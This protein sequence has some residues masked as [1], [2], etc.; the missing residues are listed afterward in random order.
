[1]PSEID[2]WSLPIARAVRQLF[3]AVDESRHRYPRQKMALADTLLSCAFDRQRGLY[4]PLA[5]D[6][7]APNKLTDDFSKVPSSLSA[8]EGT[9]FCYFSNPLLLPRRD[10]ALPKPLLRAT[11]AG[12]LVV[13]IEHDPQDREGLEEAVNWTTKGGE[14]YRIDVELSSYK[15]YAGF[16]A[17]YSGHK[18]VHLHFLFSTHHLQHAGSELAAGER[19]LAFHQHAGVIGAAHNAYYDR[20]DSL[21][22]SWLGSRMQ[23]DPSMRSYT[24]YRRTPWGIRVLERD[25]EILKL[26]AGTA[27]PQLVLAERIRTNRAAKGSSRF[28][29]PEDIWGDQVTNH[30]ASRT[31]GATLS[32]GAGVRLL[33]E[34]QL[35][36]MAA[37][38][39]E[40][41]K[42]VRMHRD[43]GEWVINFQNHPADRNPS[44]VCRGSH[45]SLLIQG[46]RASQ[47]R[48]V[49]PG[50]LTANETGNYLALRFGLMSPTPIDVHADNPATDSRFESLKRQSGRSFKQ[51][52]EAAARQSFAV[53]S[54][55]DVEQLQARYRQKLG[56]ITADCRS[57]NCH[58]I[59]ESA[60]GVGKTQALFGFM[61]E[62][63]LDT[64]LTDTDDT[65]RFNAFAFR[66]EAQAIAKAHEYRQGTG[67]GAFIWRSFWS[68]YAQVSWSLQQKPIPKAEFDEETNIASV[69]DRI[70]SEQPAVFD[71]LE[72]V[73]RTLWT[74]GDGRRLFNPNTVLFTTHATVMT[75]WV[76]RLTRTW[77]HPDF[78][79][80]MTDID[81][82]NL[83]RSVILQDVA[84][85]EPEYDELI[86]L[87][88]ARLYAHLASVKEWDWKRRPAN[89]R[90]DLFELIRRSG[91]IPA[92]MTFE[93]YSE[94]RYLDLNTLQEVEVDYWSQPFGRESTAKS[95]Y[96]ACH[97]RPFYLGA[98]E[99][100]FAGSARITFL[101]TEAFTTEAISAVYDKARQPLLRMQLDQL[102][103]LYPI[104]VPVVKE[105]RARAQDIQGLAREILNSNDNAVVIADGLGEL[106]GDRA[107]TFQ[108][109]KGHNGLSEND[110]YIIT[111]F[112]APE[113]YAR[114]NVLGQWTE[115]QD[116]VAKYYAAQISQAV[117]RN[118][119]FRQKAGTKTVVAISD[120]L[121]RLTGPALKKLDS[122]F[123]LL[124]TP[125]R[126]W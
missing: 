92:E 8:S 55:E 122:R 63:A 117:G 113:V 71:R 81:M 65:T 41:P 26:K 73:R 124:P 118:T 103:G 96:R 126:M 46:T 106:K 78:D 111:T 47:E 32:T 112:L 59:I 6:V 105:R 15:E 74:N 109:M 28:L 31:H 54:S 123:S 57:F 69:I 39:L 16:A 17:V 23:A 50:E 34:L 44:T 93:E 43:R 108:G 82:A 24:Q 35:M 9:S 76:G 70:R 67:R 115:Q 116:I 100:P 83:R 48:L 25:S 125:D 14:L 20:V 40:Y 94:L 97:Q 12:F 110:V 42:P 29:V 2:W 85:D 33:S 119:G 75:W 4:V 21:C 79:P 18:S 89:E 5:S 13:T 72:E 52:F 95:I 27:V 10:E 104:N 7:Y 99:W 58:A 36:C 121:L 61:A 56:T 120:G 45:N 88:D 64:A 84:F 53:H 107:M 90:R 38:N 91:A 80:S 22:K 51:H 86:W 77:H 3:S 66:S 114:L 1:M 62:E 87:I 102:P 49:L 101:T 19:W 68:H 98:K 30:E 37:W 11:N 60:E